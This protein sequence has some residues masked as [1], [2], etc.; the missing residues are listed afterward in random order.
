VNDEQ[1]D[2]L[3]QEAIDDMKEDCFSFLFDNMDDPTLELVAFMDAVYNINVDQDL[4]NN[5]RLIADEIMTK[6][7]EAKYDL[8]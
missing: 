6:Y 1:F 3:K 7:V 8:R 5:V 4:A 2:A